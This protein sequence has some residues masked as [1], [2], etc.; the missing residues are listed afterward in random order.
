VQEYDLAGDISGE[1]HLV[2]YHEYRPTFDRDRDEQRQRYR[3]DQWLRS[4]G[5]EERQRCIDQQCDGRLQPGRD[6]YQQRARRARIDDHG[7]SVHV[8][9][10]WNSILA[11]YGRRDLRASMK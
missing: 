2:G 9:D 7:R 11:A 8:D 10:D 5:P 3:P 6:E 4:R 1:T